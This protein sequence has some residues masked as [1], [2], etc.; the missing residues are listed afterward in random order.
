MKKRFREMGGAAF[1]TAARLGEPLSCLEGE[2]AGQAG[3]FG[4][5]F[6]AISLT[7]GCSGD[8]FQ[9]FVNFFFRQ[10][11]RL[12]DFF[13]SEPFLLQE[14]EHLLTDGARFHEMLLHEENRL[15]PLKPNY[16]FLCPL[17]LWLPAISLL[18]T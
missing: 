17:C 9:V 3:G 10:T 14:D 13:G 12:G 18:S 8:M 5:N 6:Q 11:Q 7:A 1:G 4:L 2:T 16:P 15:P